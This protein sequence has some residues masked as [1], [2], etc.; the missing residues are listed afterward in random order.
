MHTARSRTIRFDCTR[1]AR[2]L[3]SV[4]NCL[5]A[6]NGGEVRA[7]QCAPSALADQYLIERLANARSERGSRFPVEREEWLL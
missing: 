4:H 6:L 7:L 1:R 3:I 2:A 5:P